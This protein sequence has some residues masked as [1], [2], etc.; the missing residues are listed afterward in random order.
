MDEQETVEEKDQYELI[1]VRE[2]ITLLKKMPLTTMIVLPPSSKKKIHLVDGMVNLRSS[3][4]A[5]KDEKDEKNLDYDPFNIST[6]LV[7]L[8]GSSSSDD[9]ESAE[10]ISEKV[11][12]NVATTM[13]KDDE[14]L[15]SFL[16]Q[17]LKSLDQTKNVVVE[18][19]FASYGYER[20]SEPQPV[21]TFVV[22][23]I[24][25]CR[26]ETLVDNKVTS[27]MKRSSVHG[28]IPSNKLRGYK[29][30]ENIECEE[31]IGAFV[32]TPISDR[33]GAP[34]YIHHDGSVHQHRN[35]ITSAGQI[36]GRS[37]PN[38]CV[39]IV[40]DN[41]QLRSVSISLVAVK[42]IVNF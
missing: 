31:D 35:V 22:D 10:K 36:Y 1:P 9:N 41:L 14:N 38:T 42:K 6:P 20:Q 34:L 25:I 23:S 33:L 29:Q 18:D 12:L 24:C 15:V 7:D 28:D 30:L 2:F 16:K 37:V 8:S 4:L 40:S 19:Q 27:I 3:K 13:I 26:Y 5:I 17:L 32:W 21:K 39:Q 11:A